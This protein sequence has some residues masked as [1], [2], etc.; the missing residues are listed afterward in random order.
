MKLISKIKLGLLVYEH[1]NYYLEGLDI[2]RV[3]VV[4][5]FKLWILGV[6]C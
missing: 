3:I 2:I 6:G 1:L 5:I 4:N